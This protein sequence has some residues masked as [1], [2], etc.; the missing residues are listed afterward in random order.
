VTAPEILRI[1]YQDAESAY[2]DLTEYRITLTPQ[3]QGWHVD[4]ELKNPR[5]NGGGPHYIIDPTSGQI[6][7]KKYEQ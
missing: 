7:W 6:V 1:A 2:G 5:L 4:F 3:D